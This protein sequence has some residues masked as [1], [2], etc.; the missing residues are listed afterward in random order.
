MSTANPP[1]SPA[2]P[3]PAEPK[4]PPRHRRFLWPVLLLLIGGAAAAVVVIQAER[5]LDQS[6]TED[7]FVEAHIVNVAPEAVSGRIIRYFVAENELVK[8]EKVIAEIDS[9]HYRDQVSL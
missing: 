8:Q 6:S 7:A 9:T 2:P 5:R 1:P 4:P 3:P